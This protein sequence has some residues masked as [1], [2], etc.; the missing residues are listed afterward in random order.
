MITNEEIRQAFAKKYGAKPVTVLGTVA[1]VD[2][3]A[4]TCDIDD[5]GLVMYG[6]RLQCVT[7]AAGGILCVPKKG[8]AALVVQIEGGDGW[9]LADC[10]EYEKIIINGG[11]NG[12]LIKI[13]DLVGKINAIEKQVEKLK[14]MLAN[15]LSPYESTFMG[16]MA[17]EMT[18]KI[19]A[20]GETLATDRKDI[21]DTTVTH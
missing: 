12:G 14:D 3:S 5:D 10:A 7:D 19:G 21:E 18:P 1:A 20:L 2:E 13:N 15:N 6:I 16:L 9:M 17:T 8:A 4:K 11:V